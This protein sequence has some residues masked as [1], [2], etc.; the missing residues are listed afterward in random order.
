M[1]VEAQATVYIAL[2]K[3]LFVS[4]CLKIHYEQEI[5]KYKWLINN[6]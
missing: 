1:S 2:V 4:L 3:I 5:L 6:I